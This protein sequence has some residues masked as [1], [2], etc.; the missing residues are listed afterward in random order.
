MGFFCSINFRI[1]EASSNNNT[2][3]CM[4][5]LETKK[6]GKEYRAW[7]WNKRNYFFSRQSQGSKQE[8]TNED[9]SSGCWKHDMLGGKLSVVKR[10]KKNT[11]FAL[12]FFPGASLTRLLMSFGSGFFYKLPFS[13]KGGDE[14]S[15]KSLSLKAAP[16]RHSNGL[17]TMLRIALEKFRERKKLNWDRFPIQKRKGRRCFLALH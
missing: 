14:Q 16:C 4:H 3:N 6:M 2:H 7:R 15:K 10:E 5:G 17:E 13:G 1:F 8:K 9:Y 12:S 11:F